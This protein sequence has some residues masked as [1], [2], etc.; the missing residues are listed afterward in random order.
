MSDEAG[1][2][3]RMKRSLSARGWGG[4]RPDGTNAL[5]DQ[6]SCRLR[7]QQSNVEV[8]VYLLTRGSFAL[9]SSRLGPLNIREG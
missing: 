9:R 4:A 8:G 6:R 7:Y 3:D 1:S 2:K 5:T